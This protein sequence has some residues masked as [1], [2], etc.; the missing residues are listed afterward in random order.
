MANPIVSGLQNF[1]AGLRGGTATTGDNGAPAAIGNTSNSTIAAAATET[2]NQSTQTQ[3]TADPRKTPGHKRQQHKSDDSEF[4][5]PQEDNSTTSSSSTSFSP[6]TSSSSNWRNSAEGISISLGTATTEQKETAIS[7]GAS[8]ENVGYTT[9]SPSTTSSPSTTIHKPS[10]TT[11]SSSISKPT[12]SVEDI[13]IKSAG[14]QALSEKINSQETTTESTQISVGGITLG[15]GA[16]DVAEQLKSKVESE[17]EAPDDITSSDLWGSTFKEYQKQEASWTEAFKTAG[18]ILLGNVITTL[19]TGLTNPDGSLN[20]NDG[21][22]EQLAKWDAHDGSGE[23]REQRG[24]AGA[25]DVASLFIGGALTGATAKA[26]GIGLSKLSSTTAGQTVVRVA[27]SPIVNPKVLDNAA[28][29]LNKMKV[30][31]SDTTVSTGKSI[32]SATTTPTAAA[33]NTMTAVYGIDVVNRAN[34]ASPTFEGKIA[35]GLAIAAKE[36][37]IAGLGATVGYRTADKLAEIGKTIGRTEIDYDKIGVKGIPLGDYTPGSLKLS[38]EQNKLIPEPYKIARTE[39]PYYPRTSARLAEGDT[40]YLE[41]WHA[42]ANGQF[43]GRKFTVTEGSSEVSGLWTAPKAVGHFLGTN[44]YSPKPALFVTEFGASAESKAINI[45][46]NRLLYMNWNKAAKDAGISPAELRKDWNKRKAAGDAYI[47]KNADF[48]DLTAPLLKKE[49]EAVIKPGSEFRRVGRKYYTRYNGRVVK[50]DEYAPT[51]APIRD[52]IAA[53]TP[54]ITPYSISSPMVSGKTPKPTHARKTTISSSRYQSKQASEKIPFA[55][56][57]LPSP[58]ISSSVSKTT[59]LAGVTSPLPSSS[60]N[61]LTSSLLSVVGD[62]SIPRSSP[63]RSSGRPSQSSVGYSAP[64]KISP[65]SYTPSKIQPIYIKPYR[66]KK[67]QTGKTPETY[68]AFRKGRI[69]HLSIKDPL[70]FYGVGSMTNRNIADRTMSKQII[71]QVDGT[72]TH[73]KPK[74]R[75]KK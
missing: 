17:K 25:V 32:L 16:L 14:A 45:R 2:T 27:T 48:G 10:T 43:F 41:A 37:T 74:G 67:E 4:S 40:D 29:A 47:D 3:T 49:Y 57:R 68:K 71:Y 6:S 34:K 28:E 9:P 64:K 19:Q 31:V 23:Y 58:S 72:L 75:S 62:S 66:S 5:E 8:A 61:D 22:Q 50:I 39:N 30:P 63:G 46:A 56:A 11:T 65:I 53:D 51:N 24:L 21:Y 59:P 55:G 70:E 60:E 26:A 7:Q 35:A 38:F 44:N 1:I 18:D 52:S 12:A 13:R 33:I 54:K 69:D 73:H 15:G 20:W 36:L 42:T